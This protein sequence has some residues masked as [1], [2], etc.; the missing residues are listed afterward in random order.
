VLREEIRDQLI[1]DIP[2]AG[3][4]LAIASLKR[5]AEQFGESG[6][7][8][9]V[10]TWMCQFVESS[11]LRGTIVRGFGGAAAV[12]VAR[13]RGCGARRPPASLTRS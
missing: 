11:P 6:S 3:S 1:E 4:L 2:A 7:C 5:I 10:P 8:P 13:C 12:S 9:V